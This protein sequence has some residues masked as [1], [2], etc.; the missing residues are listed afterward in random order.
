MAGPEARSTNAYVGKNRLCLS[1]GRYNEPH[2][3]PTGEI[4]VLRKYA[5]ERGHDFMRIALN[6]GHTLRQKAAIDGPASFCVSV[7]V[8]ALHD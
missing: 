5:I 2:R 6:T 4:A 7:F 1:L 8:E 3:Q